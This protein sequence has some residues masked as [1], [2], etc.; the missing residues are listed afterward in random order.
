MSQCFPEP[1]EPSGVNV[2]IELDR[3]N[4]ATK[5]N[6]KEAI[7]ID[8]SMLT[9][10]KNRF[11]LKTKVN[12]LDVDKLKIAFA[13][14]SKRS[15]VVDNDIV[16]KNCMMNWLPNSVLLTLRYQTLLDYSL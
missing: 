11:G 1:Y 3:S 7:D 2:K 14:L 6:V 12:D 9:L 5:V 8:T 10:K 13:D 4:Y 16:K 15:S